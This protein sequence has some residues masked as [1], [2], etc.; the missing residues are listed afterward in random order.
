MSFWLPTTTGDIEFHSNEV[1]E[2][3]ILMNIHEMYWLVVVNFMLC[4]VL[5]CD[6]MYRLSVISQAIL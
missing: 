1:Y 3:S 5:Y 6:V 4:S 2:V